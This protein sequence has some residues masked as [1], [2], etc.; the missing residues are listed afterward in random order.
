M[1]PMMMAA[2][3]HKRP[4]GPAKY[5]PAGQHVHGQL[6]KI[7]RLHEGGLRH[8]VGAG[9]GHLGQ[10]R[11][12]ARGGHQQPLGFAR[13]LPF[14]DR[15]HG[16]ERGA[17]D[18]QVDDDGVGRLAGCLIAHQQGVA[19]PEEGGRH[20][21]QGGQGEVVGPGGQDQH[22]ADKAGQGRENAGP[23]HLLFEKE[24]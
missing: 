5:Q 4:G 24:G 14:R 17:E 12:Y 18:E 2:P 19:C 23:A 9:D 21:Q 1:A 8:A 6:G 11:Q 22:G 20:R 16:V 3:S 13:P 10:C 7:K 15:Q